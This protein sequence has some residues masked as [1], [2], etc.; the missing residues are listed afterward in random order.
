MPLLPPFLV[1]VYCTFLWTGVANGTKLFY[2][3]YIISHINLSRLFVCFFHI[4]RSIVGSWVR[5]RPEDLFED[6]DREKIHAMFE[7]YLPEILRYFA[8]SLQGIVQ[9]ND[10]S[11][12][13]SVLRLLDVILNRNIV[14][15]EMTLETAF[16]FCLIWG[17]GCILT[18]SDD[19]T[20]NRKI[21]S[22]WFRQKF[23]T[24][25][26]PSRDT[27]FDYWLDPKTSKFESWKS[28]PAFKEITF[29]STV[30]NMTEVTVPTPETASVFYWLDLLVKGGSN[31]MLAGEN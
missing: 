9:F 23:K 19:G 26:I 18:V 3:L 15:D 25:K 2:R 8:T 1:P 28:S 29:D 17:L 13:I 16:V 14:I 4:R 11:L 20:D 6:P 5:S 10:V 22:D 12:A 31:V 21:F 7:R 27:V 30:S 24:I